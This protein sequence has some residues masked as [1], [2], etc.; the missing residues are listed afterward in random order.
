MG[1]QGSGKWRRRT[2]KSTV[3]ESLAVRV[4]DFLKRADA[5]LAG[6]LTWTWAA[7]HR[8]SASYFITRAPGG[9]AVTL[10]YNWHDGERVRIP[11]RLQATPTQFGGTRWW[12]TCPLSSAG[13][14]CDRRATKLYLP[15]GSR[16][17]GCRE[18]HSLTYLSCQRA[19]KTERLFGRLD[20]LRERWG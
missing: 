14:A 16:H 8:S 20:R 19:H 5:Q 6:K 13:I 1:G 17:F 7:G 9:V 18:C 12:F 11:I 2:T 15:P 3:E 10:D 4:R